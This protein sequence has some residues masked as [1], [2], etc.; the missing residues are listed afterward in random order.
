[1]RVSPDVFTNT[2]PSSVLTLAPIP[3]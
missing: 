1:L 2:R 3:P